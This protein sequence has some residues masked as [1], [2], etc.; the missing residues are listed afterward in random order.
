MPAIFN[1]R[2]RN[3]KSGLPVKVA[4]SLGGKD[5]GYTSTKKDEWLTV[6]LSTSGTYSWY[7]RL[8]GTKI[9]EGTSSGGKMDITI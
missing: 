8:D 1:F 3:S 5:R 7:A 6:E 2:A 4:I 9:A